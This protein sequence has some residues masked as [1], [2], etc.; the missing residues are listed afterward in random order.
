MQFSVLLSR[1][2]V[3]L[4]DRAEPQLWD[5]DTLK[6]YLNEAYNEAVE[7]SRCILDRGTAEICTITLLPDVR[8][9]D[10]DPRVIDITQ[11]WLGSRP[12]C[13]MRRI[14]DA[15]PTALNSGKADFYSVTMQGNT[16]FLTLDR[17]PRDGDPVDT[18]NLEVQRYPLIP[19]TL[20]TDEPELDERKQND[21]LYWAIYLAYDNRDPDSGS[22]SKAQSADSRFTAA[23]GEKI[24]HNVRRKQLAHQPTVSRPIPF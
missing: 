17:A 23:F 13:Y 1:L 5:D 16:K 7:R 15:Y 9:Y 2:R 22:D 18:V 14:A 11:A 6:G 10:L 3:R 24:D 20:D 19:L 21:M 8:V 4:N 12:Y